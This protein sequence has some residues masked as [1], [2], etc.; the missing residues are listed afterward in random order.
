MKRIWEMRLSPYALE[1][2]ES[3]LAYPGIYSQRIPLS[4]T[5]RLLPTSFF[6][7]L[8]SLF[9]R[10][11]RPAEIPQSF[12]AQVRVRIYGRLRAA[13]G[14][15]ARWLPAAWWGAP[16]PL[17]PAPSFATCWEPAPGL[18]GGGRTQPH[19]Y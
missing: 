6:S 19:G 13:V 9:Q 14:R 16:R 18:V 1:T 10:G 7:G 2:Q 4:P 3:F 5:L 11:Q 17:G 12:G 8:R 15:R